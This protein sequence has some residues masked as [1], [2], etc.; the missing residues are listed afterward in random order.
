[1]NLDEL[2][3]IRREYSSYEGTG[4]NKTNKLG[5]SVDKFEQVLNAAI[6]LAIEVNDLKAEL[7]SAPKKHE[8]S[9][10]TRKEELEANILDDEDPCEM[11]QAADFARYG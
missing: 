9:G 5:V 11:K 8:P 2:Y 10:L 3:E 4:N 6:Y 7:R 1:M